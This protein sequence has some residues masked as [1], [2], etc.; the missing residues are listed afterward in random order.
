M[1]KVICGNESYLI[2]KKVNEAL[3]AYQQADIISYDGADKNFDIMQVIDE[4]NTPNLFADKKMVVVKNPLFLSSKSSLKD[5]QIEALLAYAKNVNVDCELLF[6]GN[7]EIDKRKKLNKELQKL[8]QYSLLEKMS[9]QE[10][11]NYVKKQLKLS[12]LD[13]SENAVNLLCNILPNDLE[14]FHHELT[15][16]CLYQA[17]I[18]EQIIKKMISV[19]LDDDVF[20]LTNAIIEKDVAKAFQKWEDLK[21]L[22]QEPIGIALIIANQFRFMY[23]V[24]YLLDRGYS[25]NEIAS[26]LKAHPYRVSLTCKN[27]RSTSANKILAILA[28]LALLDQGFKNGKIDRNIGL[29][30]FMLEIM[31]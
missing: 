26:H 15:K 29:D 20:N 1:I 14:N 17:P 3:A 23:Q 27:V 8:A 31:R 7:V 16:L 19:P 4:C 9:Y 22:K 2:Q 11:I 12:K 6:Y 30:K 5:G 18:D 25:E 28:K 21:Q 13:I 10:F 24:R